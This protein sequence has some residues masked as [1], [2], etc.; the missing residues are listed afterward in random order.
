M[1]ALLLLIL[2]L[3]MAAATF[4]STSL[5]IAHPYDK[6]LHVAYFMVLSLAV[7]F[8]I[9]SNYLAF[10]ILMT[11]AVVFEAMQLQIDARVFSYIDL[12]ANGFGILLVFTAFRIHIWRRLIRF[13]KCSNSD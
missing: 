6:V 3:G 1:N 10:A 12:A 8:T 5:N 9:K 4:P 13:P 11:T 2:A 7:L